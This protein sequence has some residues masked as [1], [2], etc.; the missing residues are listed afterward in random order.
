M[1]WNNPR[2]NQWRKTFAAGVATIVVVG[3]CS[4]PIM[5]QAGVIEVDDSVPM[6]EEAS[7]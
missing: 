1:G 2:F 5:V 6:V 7:E 3:N 4:F